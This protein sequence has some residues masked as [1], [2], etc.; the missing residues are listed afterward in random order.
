[1]Y[2]YN[3]FINNVFINILVMYYGTFFEQKHF[4]SASCSNFQSFGLLSLLLP[5]KKEKRKEKENSFS[6][7][8]K[9]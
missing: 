6:I 9:L 5:C 1:M 3:V 8:D 2:Y 7:N 4:I